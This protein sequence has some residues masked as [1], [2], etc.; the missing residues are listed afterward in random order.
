MGESDDDLVVKSAREVAERVL[1]L[2][3][4]VGKIHNPEGT[5]SWMRTHSLGLYLSASEAQFVGQDDSSH[6][7][8][9]EFSWRAE[10]VVSLL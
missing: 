3:V 4:V 1:A 8:Q 7:S 10:A 6:E 2:I 5:M 9:A